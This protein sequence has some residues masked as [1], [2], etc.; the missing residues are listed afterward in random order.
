MADGV[1]S[2][3]APKSE[4]DLEQLQQYCI[5][6]LSDAAEGFEVDRIIGGSSNPT[7]IL[8]ARAGGRRY[9]LRKKPVGKLLPSAHQVD[10]EHRV[11]SAL[12][13]VGFPVPKMHFLCEDPKIIGTAFY[14][15]DFMDGRIFRTASLPGMEKAEQAAIYDELNAVLARLHSV[16]YAAIGLADYG[17]PGNYY[18]RQ[19]ARWIRQY[20]AAEVQHTPPMEKLMEELGKAI[21]EDDSTAITHGDYRLENM[22]FHPTEP[23][24]VAVLDWELSTIGHP[25]ADLAYNCLL[26]HSDSEIF[27]NL[28]NVDFAQSGIPTETEYVAAYCRRAGLSE[29]PHFNFCLAFSQFRL[30]AIGQGVLKRA[31]EGMSDSSRVD[32]N[33]DPTGGLAA[34]A[35]YALDLLHR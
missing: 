20:R 31:R 18:E 17:R 14:V 11:M 2:M 33:T 3:A 5:G 30:L 23:R 9:V 24:I 15:M 25:I 16:D 8:T 7:F 19:L 29:L 34:R 6:K 21:P 13:T 10:R 28:K 4:L 22:I 27:G 1:D 35:Q 26:Y 12:G 32:A